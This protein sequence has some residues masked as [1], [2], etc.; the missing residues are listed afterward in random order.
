MTPFSFAISR[1][2]LLLTLPSIEVDDLLTDCFPFLPVRFDLAMINMLLRFTLFYYETFGYKGKEGKKKD[3]K[4]FEIIKGGGKSKR[5]SVP[6]P[7]LLRD[8]VKSQKMKD[9]MKDIRYTLPNII[10]HNCDGVV[11]IIFSLLSLH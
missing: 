1:R 7:Y 9:L 11:F 3:P 10:K 4:K 5:G 8:G 6:P 2:A